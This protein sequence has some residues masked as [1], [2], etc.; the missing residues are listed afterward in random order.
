MALVKPLVLDDGRIRQTRSGD[1]L[2]GS[3]SSIPQ[4]NSDP[5]SPSPGNSW[6]RAT[7]I[8]MAGSPVGLLL[9]ITQAVNTYTYELR[10]RTLE[11]ITVGVQLT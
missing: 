10:Y 6:V 5:S 2:P 9:G 7:Q 4:L 1:V 11:G 3:G 8:S